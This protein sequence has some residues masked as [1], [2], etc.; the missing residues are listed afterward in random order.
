MD[1]QLRILLKVS[2]KAL[3]DYKEVLANDE[4]V[5]TYAT[6]APSFNWKQ[7]KLLEIEPNDPVMKQQLPDYVIKYLKYLV[8]Y[9][10]IHLL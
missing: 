8:Q 3:Q 4:I 9:D 5:G 2:Q 10:I 7:A 6:A 1:P